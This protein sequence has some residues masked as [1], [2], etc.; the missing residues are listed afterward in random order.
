MASNICYDSEG[1]LLNHFYQWDVEQTVELRPTETDYEFAEGTLFHFFNRLSQKAIV[2][3]PEETDDGLVCKVPNSLLRQPET[4]QLYTY[5]PKPEG[6]WKSTFFVKIPV[7]SRKEPSDY[8]YIDDP[9]YIRLV[10]VDE[11]ILT[12]TEELT[13]I[14]EMFTIDSTLSIEGA[15][16][17]AAAVGDALDRKQDSLSDDQLENVNNAVKKTGDTVEG[18]LT[19]NM[20]FDLPS[21]SVHLPGKKI[22]VRSADRVS[23]ST[24]DR[25]QTLSLK[26]ESN[27]AVIVSGVSEPIY[28][29]DATNK[30]YVDTAIE[31]IA[32]ELDSV[33][34]DKQDKLSDEQIETINT[35]I[36][37]GSTIQIEP[38]TAITFWNPDTDDSIIVERIDAEDGGVITDRR[39]T[40]FGS[41]HVGNIRIAV[42]GD[43]KDDFDLCNKLYADNASRGTDLN[44]SGAREGDAV[45]VKTVSNGVPTSFAVSQFPSAESSDYKIAYSK[46]FSNV[47]A[48]TDSSADLTN[49]NTA[50]EVIFVIQVT[51]QPDQQNKINCSGCSVYT[52]TKRFR[53]INSDVIGNAGTS[54]YKTT[55]FSVYAKKLYDNVWSGKRVWD[56]LGDGWSSNSIY[57]GNTSAS[58]EAMWNLE[59]SS[60]NA[61]FVM[62]VN[63]PCD[64]DV[65]ILWK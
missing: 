7:V 12:A 8:V 6:G 42:E 25:M 39:I 43:P 62:N 9:D 11:H 54:Q 65:K 53:V 57:R 22:L 29:N 40:F 14:S 47:S 48:I 28:D 55:C 32:D 64:I 3:E 16:A 56:P 33:K 49:L 2:V 21:G 37:K 18:S 10:D 35:A 15:S 34:D 63:Y 36:T 13:R 45:I 5:E 58:G 26:N 31:N 23:E 19:L 27:E 52:G 20:G 51:A 59:S 44:L 17:D 61:K 24:A 30:A 60:E 38:D 50:R 41:D 1:N 4:I 46:S